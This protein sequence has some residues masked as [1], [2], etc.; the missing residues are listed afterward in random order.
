[1]RKQKRGDGM[2]VRDRNEKMM[3]KS[4]GKKEKLDQRKGGRVRERQ[5]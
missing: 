1:M 5:T 4:C 2:R 3:L